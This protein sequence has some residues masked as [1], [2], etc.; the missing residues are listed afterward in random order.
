MSRFVREIG[1]D[2]YPALRIGVAEATF[3]N[4]AER[5]PQDQQFVYEGI[6]QE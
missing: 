3:V 5:R 1:L 2:S 6:S 4:R